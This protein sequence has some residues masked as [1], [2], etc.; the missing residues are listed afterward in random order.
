MS[1]R[2]RTLAGPALLLVAAALLVACGDS[3]D[4]TS[5][6]SGTTATDTVESDLKTELDDA[7]QSCLDAAEKISNSTARS[8]AKAAC[9]QLESSLAGDI[10]QAADEAKGNVS[11]ALKNLAADCRKTASNLPA[12]GNVAGSFCDAISASADSVS[13]SGG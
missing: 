8:A 6:S 2:A 1:R 4:S 10:T 5:S 11:E 13:S 12:G 7:T 3:S 9:D